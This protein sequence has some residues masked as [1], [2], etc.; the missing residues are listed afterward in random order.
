MHALELHPESR[1]AGIVENRML[2]P[3]SP[4]LPERSGIILSRETC[5]DMPIPHIPR[6]GAK[7]WAEGWKNT[8]IVECG[9]P[10]VLV[11]HRLSGVD[12]KLRTQSA[13]IYQNMP[14]IEAFTE[15]KRH[16]PGAT[17]DI[18]VR[19][20]VLEALNKAAAS[21][22]DGYCLVVFDGYREQIVQIMLYNTML[23]ILM[24]HR[25]MSREEALIEV[26]KYVSEPQIDPPAP[27]FTG[28]AA[29]VAIFDYLTG[30]M[31]DFGTKFDSMAPDS[32]LRYFEENEPQN[33]QEREA[34]INRRWLYWLMHRVG[35]RGF[36]SE[37]WHFDH[38]KDPVGAYISGRDTASFGYAGEMR[39][40][41]PSEL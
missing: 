27:H 18:Y 11:N 41:N 32:A 13:Y 7:D 24:V 21:L 28:G 5:A 16:I 26:Q 38:V 20:T 6:E 33:V 39:R 30:E 14:W 40:I 10:L 36:P 9:E 17:P 12:A 35:F 34:Q 1:Q 8:P 23:Q 31:L 15:E 3:P 19:E 37:W 25:G 2:F 29:D 4:D 22:P